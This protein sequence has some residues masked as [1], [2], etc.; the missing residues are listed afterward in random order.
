MKKTR[1]SKTVIALACTL[2]LALAVLVISTVPARTQESSVKTYPGVL[3]SRQ[4][5][6]T[7]EPL[8]LTKHVGDTNY[9]FLGPGTSASCSS[10][11]CQATA[12]IFTES[13]ECPGAVNVECTFEIDVAGQHQVSP[14][15][16]DGLYQFFIDGAIPS[17]GGT[18]GSG[19]YAWEINGAAGK[20]TSA[21]GVTSQ[22]KN[23]KANELHSIVVNIG[24]AEIESNSGGCSDSTGF[25]QLTIRVLKP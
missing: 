25:H 17:G 16:E 11:D 14:A 23:T 13:I 19:L 7:V 4:E 20:Y 21:Y 5:A 10:A 2:A 22:V 24:C 15:G 1:L 8:V 12:N 18:D 6:P 3:V 9:Y